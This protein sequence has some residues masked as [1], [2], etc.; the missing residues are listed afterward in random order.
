MKKKLSTGVAL[1]LFTA[2]Y[3]PSHAEEVPVAT[4]M[5]EVVVTAGRIAESKK[6]Q[7]VNITVI[8][9]EEIAASPA[10]DLGDLL[11]EKGTGYI[12]K[13]PGS[14]TTIG[15][16]GF[17]TDTHGNDLRGHVLVLLNGRRAGTGNVAKISTRNIERIEIIRGPG[18]VQYGSAAVGGVINV[19]TRQG[20]GAPSAELTGTLG[21]FS[22]D[23]AGILVSGEQSGFDLSASFSR[24][25]MDDYDTGSGDKFKN[26]GFDQKDSISL[27]L[28]YNLRNHRVGIIYSQYDADE[29][30][31]P[32]YLSN[33]DLDNYTDSE[34]SSIDFIY[35]GNTSSKDMFWLVRYFDGE[36][37]D[38]W[39]DPTDSNASGWDDG[40]PDKQK[41]DHEGFQ[42]QIT[43]DMSWLKMTGGIDW[44]DY[45]MTTTWTPEKTEYE[46]TGYFLLTKAK[47]YEDHIIVDVGLRYDTYDVEVSE[48]AGNSEDDNNVTPSIGVAYLPTENLK[49]R[50]QYGEAFVM[51]GADQ[52]AAD[53]VIWGIHYV[54]NPDLDPESSKTYEVGV[55]YTTNVMS[56]SLSYFYTDFEDKIETVSVA[57]SSTWDNVGE[58]EISGIEGLFSY[59]IGMRLGWQYEVKPY[60]NFVYLDE[61]R[62]EENDED[63]KYTNDWNASYGLSISDM[64]GFSSRLNFSY[65]GRQTVDDWE[66]GGWPTP[67]VEMGGFTVADLSLSKRFLDFDQYGTFTVKGDIINLFDKEYAYV[68]GY[69]MPGRSLFMSL[70]YNY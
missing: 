22:Y 15:I 5:D 61:Y 57:G 33:N 13:Y 16:R 37:E 7:T 38:I 12:K 3:V 4:T 28:G 20:E 25:S 43:K 50:A 36:D 49:I 11:A 54:G 8:D 14:L 56:A 51:P 44:L 62:D 34:L 53:Y 70:T 35:T 63:L 23:E 55:D 9:A 46:N 66:T 10:K 69:P 27:N 26:T 1:L 30:G 17:K 65:T 29:I 41:T 60:V 32:F 48:P 47:F 21:S 2:M 45:E 31:N 68:K 64:D 19:I 40:I 24:S 18:A 52:L 59:D 39:H 58:A 67:E 6:E 42:A